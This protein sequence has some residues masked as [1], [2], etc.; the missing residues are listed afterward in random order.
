MPQNP[1]AIAGRLNALAL[2]MCLLA[3]PWA[4]ADEQKIEVTRNGVTTTLVLPEY[5]SQGIPYA[6]LADLSRQLGGSV[7]VDTARAAVTLG[8]VRAEIGLNDVAVQ[9]G[10]ERFSLAHPVLPYQSDALIAMSDVLTFLQVGYGMG[11]PDAPPTAS[12]LA[13]SPEEMPLEPLIPDTATPAPTD[14]LEEAELESISPTAVDSLEDAPLESITTTPPPAIPSGI[15]VVAIDPGHGGDDV[16][17]V[18]TSGLAEKGL[19][20]TIATSLRRILSERYGLTT[21]ATRE[22]DDARTLQNRADIL[23]SSRAGLVVSIHAGA[24]YA[25]EAQGP[26][27]FAHTTTG[28][29]RTA[30]SVAQTLAKSVGT[31]SAPAPPAVHGVALGLMRDATI[32]GVLRS[33]RNNWPPQSRRASTRPLDGPNRGPPRNEPEFSPDCNSEAGPFP[34]GHGHAGTAFCRG[35]A[36]ARYRRQWPRSHWRL[37]TQ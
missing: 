36:G 27:L 37:S 22:G 4:D 26:A 2:L 11:T 35:A 34:L 12:A 32:P 20:L 25:T 31:V 16:G 28:T 29:T 17:I 14:A 21:V 23:A 33:I 3:S 13:L 7:E 15:T 10:G 1:H 6:S 8:E 19:C 30:V 18:G 9:R 5:T 24:S